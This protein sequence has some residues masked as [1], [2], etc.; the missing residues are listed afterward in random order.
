MSTAYNLQTNGASEQTNKMLNQCVWF[1]VEWNQKGWVCTLPIIHF[2][3]MN[4]VNALTGYS[5]F[6]I[7]MGWSPCIISPLFPGLV[8]EP[9]SEKLAACSI[10]SQIKADVMDAK[11]A[12]LGV[13]ILHT[14]YANRGCGHEDIYAIGD[15]VMLTTLH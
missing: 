5:G 7:C 9:T 8:T 15:K 14:F 2:N 1:H 10:I 3:M 11:D 13:K 4:L 12:L 6:Q